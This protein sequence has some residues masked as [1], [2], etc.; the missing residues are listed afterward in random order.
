MR[1]GTRLATDLYFQ[2]LDSA[3]FESPRLI[4]PIEAAKNAGFQCDRTIVQA[5]GEVAS[6]IGAGRHDNQD[7]QLPV[8]LERTPYDKSDSKRV[9]SAN[10]FARR[11]YVYALQ[12]VRGRYQSEG[13]WYPLVG[14]ETDGYDTIEWLAAQPWSDGQVGTLGESYSATIQSSTAT[15]APPGLKSMIVSMGGANAYQCGLRHNGA[16]ELRMLVYIMNLARTSK[17][18]LADKKIRTQ[19]EAAYANIEEWINRFPLQPGESPLALVPSYERWLLDITKHGAYDAYW[20]Q[21]SYAMTDYRDE[22]AHVPTLYIGGWFD[23]YARSAWENFAFQ[24]QRNHETQALLM[25]PWIHKRWEQSYAGELDFGPST[26]LNYNELRLAWLNYTLRGIETE[27]ATWSPVRIFVM[28]TGSGE[29]NSYGRIQHNGEWRHQ[30]E[31]ASEQATLIS[32]YLHLEGRLSPKPPDTDSSTGS[33]TE[34]NIVARK[35]SRYTYD[36]FNPV[37]TIG[38]GL[39]GAYDVMEPGP[40]DQRASPE[41][42]GCRNGLPL[43]TRS[44]VLTFQSDPL[45]AD[46]EV[47]GPICVR[48]YASSSA[49][50]TDFTAKLIDFFPPDEERREG[51]AINL[52]DSIIRARYRNGGACAELLTPGTVYQFDLQLNPIANIFRAGHRIRLDI[53]SSNF[54]RFDRN[55]NTGGNMGEREPPQIAHQAI[56]HNIQ[57]PSQLTLPVVAGKFSTY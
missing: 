9:K 46:L 17:E 12:D 47:V 44:D 34:P 21:P 16:L 19:L 55:P 33:S 20:Q 18:A 38:G 42:F 37:P 40:F 36:P 5:G 30:E 35:S 28:G 10:Y 52:A 13:E 45:E 54:P 26:S 8:L 15:L 50:D 22:H 23:V 49:L 1:D 39:A 31:L 24:E 56:F 7:N 6:G 57:Y 53:S 51:T 11:G 2:V 27:A 25:G 32:L 41:F 4:S 3:P 29:T 43:N 14:E 48:L